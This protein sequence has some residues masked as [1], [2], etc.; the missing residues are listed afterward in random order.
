MLNSVEL[1]LTL[2]NSANPEHPAFNIL[3]LI[4]Y[5]TISQCSLSL[6]ANAAYKSWGIKHL[7]LINIP[8][9]VLP[10]RI[11]HSLSLYDVTR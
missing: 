10:R 6:A 11:L 3:S 9:G 4:H 5:L 7:L 1:H 2:L 8:D